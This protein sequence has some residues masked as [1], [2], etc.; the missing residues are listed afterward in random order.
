VAFDD[1]KGQGA[2]F[3]SML[4][5]RAIIHFGK[6]YRGDVRDLTRY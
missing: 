5:A 3:C 1:V 2:L 6:V 4:A